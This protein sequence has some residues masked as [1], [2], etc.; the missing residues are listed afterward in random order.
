MMSTTG[1]LDQ[2]C[3]S[4][5]SSCYQPGEIQQLENKVSQVIGY[6]DGFVSVMAKPRRTVGHCR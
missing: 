2:T 1:E 5:A 3:T 6:C 4:L